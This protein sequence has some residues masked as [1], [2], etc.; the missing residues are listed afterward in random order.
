VSK[1]TKRR[2]GLGRGGA[3]ALVLCTSLLAAAPPASAAPSDPLFVFSPVPPPPP[4][5]PE[6]PPIGYLNGPCGLAVDAAGRFWL[7]DHYHRAV[8]VFSSVP[9]YVSQALSASGLPNPH[10]RA[11]DDPCGLALSSTGTLYLNNYHRNVA[12]FPAPVSAGT[13]AVLAGSGEATGVAVSP[14]TSHAYV[15]VRDHVREYDANGAFVQDIGAAS[16]T[17]GYGIAVSGYP[18][19]AGHLYVPDAASN[20]IKVYDPAT[21]T[22][23]PIEEIA[24]PSGG[25]TSLAD[26]SVAVDDVTGTI[27]ALDNVQP[28]R[29]E[30]PRA[31]V[32]VFSSAGAYQGHLKYD[33]IGA[34]PAGIAVDNSATA[35][36]GRVYVTTGN[37]HQAGVYVYGPG[38]VTSSAPLAPKFHPPLL[39]GALLFPTV[40]IGGPGGAAGEC[41]A[42]ACQTLPPEP[43]DPTL[44]TLLGGHGN[45]KPRYARYNRREGAKKKHRKRRRGARRARASISTIAPAPSGL[46]APALP[47]EDETASVDRGPASS[48]G[49]PSM[50][51]LAPTASSVL[52]PASAGFDAQAW[53]DGGAA[54]TQA[55]SHPYEVDLSLGLDQSGAGQDLRSA[56]LTLPPGLLLNPANGTGVLCSDAAFAASRTT[57]FA[58]PVESGESC[59]DMAQVGTVEVSTGLGGGKSA[60]FGLFNRDPRSGYAARFGASPFGYPLDLEMKIAAERPGANFT[61]EEDEVPQALHLESMK[62]TLWG[63]PWDASHNTE[64]GD[65]LNEEESSFALGKCSAGEPLTTKPRAFLTMP[66]ACGAPLSFQAQA[67][68]W[69]GG[70]ESA[71]REGAAPVSG[72]ASPAFNLEQEGLLSVKKA[73]SGSGYFYRFSNDDQSHVDPRGQIQA[74]A[75]KVTVQ[76]PSGVTLNPSVGAGLGTCSP[77][78]LA[79][80]TAFNAPGEGCPNAAKIGIFQVGLPYFTKRLRGSIYLAKPYDNPFNSLL[81]VYLIAKSADRGMLFRI[82]G[83]LTPDG[84]GTLT[85]TFDDLPQLPYTDL[86]IGFRS[87]QRAPLV[88]PP[89]CGAAVSTLTLT[90]WASGV[91]DKVFT[92][93]SPIETGADAGPCP[94]GTPPFAP[95]AVTGGV[96]ANVGSYTPYY[97]H[98]E[99]QD[100]EQEITSYSLVLPKGITGKLAGVPFCP[101]QSIEAARQNGGFAEAEHPSCPA[102]SQVGRTDTGYGVGDALTYAQGRIYLAGPYHGAPLSLVTIN[103]ATVGPFDLGT[104]VIRSAFQVDQRTAQLRIDSS[105]SDP[106]PHIID[107]IP[108]HLRDVRIYMDRFHFTHNPSSCEPSQL[109]STLTGSGQTFESKADDSSA[110]V[111]KHFQLLNCLTLGF[112][113]KLGMRLR[114]SFTRGGFPSLR[115]SFASR[116]AKDSN[117]KK[118]EVVMPH[119]EFLA[120]G[121]IRTVC[122][123]PLFQAEKCPESSV[124]GSAVA[125]TLLFDDP[126]RGN[127]YLRASSSKLPDLVADLHAGAVR[128]VVEGRIGPGRHGGIL[129]FFDNLP[130]APIDSFTMTLFGGKRGLLQNSTNI[131]ANPPIAAVKAL[132]QN[133]RGAIFTTVLRGQCK[134]KREKDKKGR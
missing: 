78:Q 77:A 31:R 128:I 22:D 65:C 115:A 122:A 75:K 61:L 88:S 129:A 76:L 83:K 1:G 131:C 10:T 67:S 114:G 102:A 86:E 32:E 85:A 49:A 52:L 68:S 54:A 82:P 8:S 84:E 110:T 5:P 123:R 66:G 45:P 39:G 15:N 112:H 28:S 26:S 35:T 33:V 18:A 94:S 11:Y 9:K 118:I 80:E 27:Y 50:S 20:T 100:T 44:T 108:L 74:L 126:L 47:S 109:E 124:Y 70:S 98:L 14:S 134:G 55:G 72:C 107:G 51:A 71:I 101:E 48:A 37:T 87:G 4:T 41:E 23:D 133:N 127:V 34:A 63:V 36:Q 62:I 58:A 46:S 125:K 97:V 16:L 38:A 106:I 99:R 104:I 91:K 13:G 6:P 113:P 111:A 60:T 130:D 25:F 116:G 57:P 56:R 12:R 79:A 42:D 90:P 119:S 64:R 40:S 21:D 53:A 69:Q 17:G 24:G 132:G 73:S 7:S 2:R 19:S 117:L 120:Q 92:T 93:S 95:D 3:L 30:E 103:S 43:V 105:A 121:H 81:A 29:T 96:N 59:P 89:R